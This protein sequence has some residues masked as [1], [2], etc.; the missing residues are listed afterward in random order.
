MSTFPSQP[1]KTKDYS[2]ISNSFSNDKPIIVIHLMPFNTVA[3]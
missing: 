1:L 2:A 3:N